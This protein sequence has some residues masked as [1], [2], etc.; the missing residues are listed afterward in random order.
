MGSKIIWNGTV[1]F[2]GQYCP[3]NI[4]PAFRTRVETH[5]PAHKA[6]LSDVIEDFTQ[7]NYA[8]SKW[9]YDNV[10][11][12]QPSFQEFG[13]SDFA[14][15]APRASTLLIDGFINAADVDWLW[16]DQPYAIQS[17][18][19]DTD[20]VYLSLQTAMRQLHSIGF[21]LIDLHGQT[22]M[23]MIDAR[24]PTLN[25][26]TLNKDIGTR[27]DNIAPVVNNRTSQHEALTQAFLRSIDE[28]INGWAHR[29]I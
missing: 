6:G 12:R 13:K 20:N 14:Q 23:V 1:E 26:W 5:I 21:G 7:A 15:T 25:L 29:P 3:V 9:S 10:G 11:Q 2:A 8:P 4:L 18:G 27:Y 22:Q 16:L 19:E 24:Q 28:S 17:A